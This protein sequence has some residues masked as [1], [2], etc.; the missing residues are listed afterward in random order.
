MIFTLEL[1]HS[2][3]TNALMAVVWGR[4]R[5]VDQYSMQHWGVDEEA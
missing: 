4:E 2:R 3:K 1:D 5:A